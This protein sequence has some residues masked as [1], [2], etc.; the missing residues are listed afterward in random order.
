[1]KVIYKNEK[2]LHFEEKYVDKYNETKPT[3]NENIYY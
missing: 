1:M 3:P 2:L